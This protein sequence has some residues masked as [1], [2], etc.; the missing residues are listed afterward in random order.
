M[1][2]LLG[3]AMYAS[4]LDQEIERMANL[5]FSEKLPEYA[6][7]S[8]AEIKD[9]IQR[10]PWDFPQLI[11]QAQYARDYML[12][13]AKDKG[14]LELESALRNLVSKRAL[15]PN[16]SIGDKVA[17]AGIDFMI[18]FFNVPLNFA[19]QGLERSVGAPIYAGIGLKHAV[20]GHPREAAEAFAKSAVGAAVLGSGAWLAGTD[21]L[22]GPGPSPESGLRDVWLLDHQPYSYRIPGTKNW[23]EYGNTPV[24]IPWGALAGAK[25]AWDEAKLRGGKKGLADTEM[26]GSAV[27]KGGQGAIHGAFSN[28]FL[29]GIQ[30]NFET[31]ALQGLGPSSASTAAA[32]ALARYNPVPLPMGTLGF[33]AR[34]ADTMDRDVGRITKVSE[35][36]GDIQKRLE[37]RFPGLRNTLPERENAFGQPVANPSGGGWAISPFRVGQGQAAGDPAQ[38]EKAQKLEGVG[39]GM[40]NAPAELTAK[41]YTIP[42]E[43]EEQR[44][45]QEVWGQEYSKNLDLLKKYYPD[46]QF[47]DD[48]YTRARDKAREVAQGRVAAQIG[49]D[50]LLRRLREQH[51][52][53]V[54]PVR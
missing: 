44:R 31:L 1:D 6:G 21:N 4:K 23:V 19:K 25:E 40:P 42:L 51:A 10:N 34:V 24:A 52:R 53:V 38:V 41:G 12:L 17:A 32:N 26:L 35:I 50:E 37:A 33:F 36:P 9:S 7:M 39:V 28:T 47:P 29:E 49:R 16:A 5:K 46:R 11:D 2:A 18:P 30:Q 8:K 13:R 43:P 54:E 15:G 48:V 22:T 20:Q 14:P 45:F 3:H 27:M